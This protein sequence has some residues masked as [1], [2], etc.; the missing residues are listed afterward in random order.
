MSDP[1]NPP[2]ADDDDWGSGGEEWGQPQEPQQPPPPAGPPPQQQRPGG[3]QP[4]PPPT[5]GGYQ[6][7]P[8][9]PPSGGYQASPPQQGPGGYQAP[10]PQ[11]PG[12]GGQP[13]GYVGPVAQTIPNYLVFS[14]LTTLFCC[15][16]AGVV[17]IIYS[18]QVN[19][20]LSQGDAAGAKKASDNAKL[21]SIISVG[22][23]VLFWLFIVIVSA[24]SE[25]PTY[26]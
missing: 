22:A 4:P 18:S 25:D 2:P 11:Q 6:A 14:I 8:P 19:T 16:P 17:G 23:G 9:P 13:P 20:K 15:L 1:N 24:A 5:S 21:W 3:Y 26:Y 7:P 12:Y 10:P